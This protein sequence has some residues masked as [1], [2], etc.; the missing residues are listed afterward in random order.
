MT[1]KSLLVS[2]RPLPDRGRP[3]RKPSAAPA[4]GSLPADGWLPSP[5][6]D[7]KTAVQPLPM[8]VLLSLP[9]ALPPG[10]SFGARPSVLPSA[11]ELSFGVSDG[12]VTFAPDGGVNW[13]CAASG[14]AK[15]T[16]VKPTSKAGWLAPL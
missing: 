7:T 1:V 11:F 8:T 9:V 16:C 14:R 6:R 5:T 13:N 12:S 4:L 15:L 3:L 10:R 2:T